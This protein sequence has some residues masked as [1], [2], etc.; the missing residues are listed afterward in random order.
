M[1]FSA[2]LLPLVCPAGFLCGPGSS[3]PTLCP[4]SS[5]CPVQ[6]LSGALACPT[7]SVCAISGLTQYQSVPCLAGRYCPVDTICESIST[8]F[9]CPAGF[10][11]PSN[12]SLPVICPNNMFCPFA[13]VEPIPCA[14]S[15][16]AVVSSTTVQGASSF[17]NCTGGTRSRGSEIAAT[18]TKNIVCTDLPRMNV[19][20]SI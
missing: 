20:H 15:A 6:G 10:F 2:A 5:I 17:V 1:Y 8:S 19:C 11:C 12:S 18:T 13:A 3:Y 9:G 14:S 4:S 16:F 7:G